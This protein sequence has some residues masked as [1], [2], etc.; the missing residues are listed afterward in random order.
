MRVRGILIAVLSIVACARQ[1]TTVGKTGYTPKWHVGDWWITKTLWYRE[2]GHGS[3]WEWRYMRYDMAGIEKVG[4]ND[5]YVVE[6]R[7]GRGANISTS[8]EPGRVLYIR[9]DKWLIIRE[10]EMNWSRGE[11]RPP[12]VRDYP[13]GLFGP[14][15]SE[16]RIPRFPLQLANQDTAFKLEYRDYCAADLREISCPADPEQVERLLAEGDTVDSRAIRPSG[17]VYQVRSELGG[18]RDS[19]APTGRKNI[20]QS[21]QLWSDDLPWRLFEELAEYN[22]SYGDRRVEERSWLVATSRQRR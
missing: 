2:T 1:F 8:G 13:L 7:S 5:C 3:F 12:S 17:A 9:A 21:L 4:Q 16:Q 11:S 15:I 19:S 14:F 10:K 22:G 6:M 18:N 20:V